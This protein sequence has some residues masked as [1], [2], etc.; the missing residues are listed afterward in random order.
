MKLGELIVTL[1]SLP[2]DEEVEFDF[3]YYEPTTLQSWRGDYSQLA[4]GHGPSRFPQHVTV[5]ALLDLCLAADGQIMEGWKG[6]GYLMRR[7]TA[8]YVDNPGEYSNTKLIAVGRQY[9]STVILITAKAEVDRLE[10]CGG[11]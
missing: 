2:P 4:L 8:V 3:G 1:E 6:G 10:A 9:G 5:K 7:N 11:A